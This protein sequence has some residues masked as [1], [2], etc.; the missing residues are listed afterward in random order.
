MWGCVTGPFTAVAASATSAAVEGLGVSASA[1]RSMDGVRLTLWRSSVGRGMALVASDGDS[2]AA[3]LGRKR[4]R[5]IYMM[6]IVGR[7]VVSPCVHDIVGRS[8]S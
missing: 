3:G 2:R 1:P 7:G 6:F 4:P 5:R 8:S